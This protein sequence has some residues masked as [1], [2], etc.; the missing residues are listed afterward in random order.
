MN[1]EASFRQASQ[2]LRNQCFL[3]MEAGRT[4]PSAYLCNIDALFHPWLDLMGRTATC[5]AERAAMGADPSSS[6]RAELDRLLEL[7]QAQLTEAIDHLNPVAAARTCL[8]V[9]GVQLAIEDLSG[10]TP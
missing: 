5:I 10:A 4:E 9:R 1:T 2:T 7:A 6:V 3:Q 8:F